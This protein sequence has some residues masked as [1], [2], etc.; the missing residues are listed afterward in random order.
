VKKIVTLVTLKN[1]VDFDVKAAVFQS[2]KAT[3]PEYMI[4][5]DIKVINEIPLN[6]NGKADRIKLTEIYL[7][8]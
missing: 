3:L 1:E 8:R 7:Q 6:Q 2:L 5:S 4:P